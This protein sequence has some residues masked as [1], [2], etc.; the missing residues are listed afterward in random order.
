M[1]LPVDYLKFYLCKI[2]DVSGNNLLTYQ[3]SKEWRHKECANTEK[4]RQIWKGLAEVQSILNRAKKV[5]WSVMLSILLQ[6]IRVNN[7]NNE[8]GT[9]YKTL[10]TSLFIRHFGLSC[11]VRFEKV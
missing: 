1:S 6:Q 5:V 9:F 4:E 2:T 7:V 8:I 3:Y 11:L 10:I